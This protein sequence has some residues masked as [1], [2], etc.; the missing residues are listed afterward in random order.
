MNVNYFS[1]LLRLPG[2]Q[3]D[4]FLQTQRQRFGWNE[5]RDVPPYE[6]PNLDHAEYIRTLDGVRH[7][8]SDTHTE[9]E[10]MRLRKEQEQLITPPL[11]SASMDNIEFRLPRY[12]L[13]RILDLARKH[14][15]SVVFLYTPRYGGPPEPPPYQRYANRAHLINPWDQVQDYYLWTDDTHVN[16]EGAKRITDFVAQALASRKELR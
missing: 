14:G 1:N 11:L 3:V 2:R 12:Y 9:A 16:W 5:P 10:M 4:L 8:R 15:T 13:N 6:G 7:N